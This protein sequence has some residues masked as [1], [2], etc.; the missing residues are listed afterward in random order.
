MDTRY[1]Y[2]GGLAMGCIETKCATKPFQKMV[3][4]MA[5]PSSSMNNET[6][7]IFSI[8]SVMTLSPAWVDT[9]ESSLVDSL[10]GFLKG[11]FP[12]ITSPRS[13]SFLCEPWVHFFTHGVLHRY[14]LTAQTQRIYPHFHAPN[15]MPPGDTLAFLDLS[16]TA[17]YQKMI[18]ASLRG[19][20]VEFSCRTDIET[21]KHPKAGRYAK[22]CAYKSALPKSTR[23][24]I[25]WLSMGGI[26]FCQ[27]AK[28]RI[29]CAPNRDFREALCAHLQ[30]HLI[31]P[32]P[33]LTSWISGACAAM[34]PLALLEHLGRSWESQQGRPARLALYSSNA[35]DVMDEWKIYALA[36]KQYHQTRWIGSPHALNHGSLAVFWQR[37]F[38]LR[39][40]DHYLSWGWQPLQQT[41]AH[42]QAFHP[43]QF[44][45]KQPRACTSWDSSGG[46][47]ISSAGRPKHLLEYPYEPAR[48][49]RYLQTQA[50]LA[51]ALQK[52]TGQSVS[53]RT[54]PKDLG[55]D[56]RQMIL[57]LDNPAVHLEFQVGP[58]E[59]RLRQSALHI[60]DNFSTTVVESLLHN[61]P[62]LVLI[63]D[64]YFQL[65]PQAQ[66]AWE[67]L[68]QAGIAHTQSETLL[69]Q[70]SQI[71]ND[72]MGWWTRHITQQAIRTFLHQQ[73]RDAGSA[74]RWSQALLQ[75]TEQS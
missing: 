48:F 43:P 36:Q 3:V 50:A 61:H 26:R 65:H 7:T 8:P 12:E 46:I 14:E 66:A 23:Y 34:L 18:D 38:E 54:R 49:E 53:I 71:Q 42:V 59:R 22:L 52:L 72:V 69:L 5:V 68:A 20:S 64:D 58:F 25:P 21:I 15:A 9:I 33:D 51:M 2:T 74:L 60:S 56:L 75:L 6:E 11:Q 37:E 30:S 29:Q 44:P 47:L 4:E 45:F 63:T 17:A 35:W 28:E 19:Q 32:D 1:G 55:W 31:T 16:R 13:F 27:T 73:A 67:A 24:S 39:H 40:L 70:V 57:A 62:T 41:H 10:S